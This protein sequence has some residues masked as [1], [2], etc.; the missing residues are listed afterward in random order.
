MNTT[1]HCDGLCEP[2]NPGGYACWAWVITDAPPDTQK[3]FE[4]GCVASGKGATN[5]LA[6]Y[7]AVGKALRYC[8]DHRIFNPT[9]RSDSQLVVYQITGDWTCN[10]PHLKPLH[11]RC[12]ELLQAVNGR[13]VWIPRE[14]NQVADDYTREAYRF[15][16]H[17]ILHSSKMYSVSLST[18]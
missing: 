16:Q 8:Y 14:A 13:I 17:G 11:S 10:A 1:I 5:N 12:Q 7:T 18:P 3:V 6:E 4:W 15:A 9:I 2:K